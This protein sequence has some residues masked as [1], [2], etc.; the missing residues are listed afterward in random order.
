MRAE[1]VDSHELLHDVP[2][3]DPVLAHASFPVFKL[4]MGG[5]YDFLLADHVRFGI[6]G[7]IS[8]YGVPGGLTPFYG[9]DPTSYM[10]FVRLKVS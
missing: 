6:G 2:D 8:K 1:R 7:L 3:I 9:S 10:A 4:S 5:I